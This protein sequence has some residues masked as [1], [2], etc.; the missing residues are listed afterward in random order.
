MR[1]QAQWKAITGIG[2]NSRKE[3]KIRGINS[4]R[5]EKRSSARGKIDASRRGLGGCFPKR[6]CEDAK[7]TSEMHASGE[8]R[9]P[10]KSRVLKF[11]IDVE[12]ARKKSNGGSGADSDKGGWA[13]RVWLEKGTGR[14]FSVGGQGGSHQPLGKKK[15]EG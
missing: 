11:S 7:R 13:S 3:D 14:L 15:S 4:S 12:P 8:D 6:G 10:Q 9:W 2:G 1:T 5:E